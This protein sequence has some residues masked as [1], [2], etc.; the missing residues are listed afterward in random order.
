M[1][2]LDKWHT[3]NFSY[4]DR[5]VVPHTLLS[6]ILEAEKCLR[7]QVFLQKPGI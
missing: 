2:F 6:G 5:V 4:G 3:V 7:Y 1:D